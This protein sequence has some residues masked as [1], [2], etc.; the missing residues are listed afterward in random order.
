M[1]WRRKNKDG[2]CLYGLLSRTGGT[3]DYCTPMPTVDI[4]T[5]E[6]DPGSS[7]LQS[8]IGFTPGS[9]TKGRI[10]LRNGIYCPNYEVHFTHIYTFFGI[11][12]LNP[13]CFILFTQ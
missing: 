7:L 2:F 10:H 3:L 9:L 13:E 1:I 4:G 6:I 5:K 11:S 12:H 8:A